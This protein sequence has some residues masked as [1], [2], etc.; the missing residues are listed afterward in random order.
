M[1][2]SL[3]HDHWLSVLIGKKAEES[4]QFGKMGKDRTNARNQRVSRTH[5]VT[6]GRTGAPLWLRLPD[7]GG[8]TNAQMCVSVCFLFVCMFL[9]SQPVK[10]N[11]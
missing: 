11:L 6:A 8:G 4:S 5:G 1:G 10:I 7:G 3:E 2:F 9:F